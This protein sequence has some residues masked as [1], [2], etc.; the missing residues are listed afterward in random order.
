VERLRAALGSLLA[1]TGRREA[2]GHRAREAAA[3]RFG[4]E[5]MVD[6]MIEVFAAAS[7]ARDG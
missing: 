7:G 5:R 6:R 4:D 1:D 2:L 3:A